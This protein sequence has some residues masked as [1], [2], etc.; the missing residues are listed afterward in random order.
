MIVGVG[1]WRGTGATT[2]AMLLAGALGERAGSAWLVEADAAGGVLASRLGLAHDD[3]DGPGGV[4]IERLASARGDRS[5]EI[6]L[7]EDVG[8]DLGT[9]TLVPAPADPFRAAPCLMSRVGW[10]R[11]L[12]ELSAPVVVDL[13]RLRP[14]AV[15]WPVVGVVDLLLVVT[16]PD[17]AA[18]VAT[19]DWIAASGQVT[20]GDTGFG[21]TPARIAVVDVPG[22]EQ[23]FSRR[24]AEAELGERLAGWL[25]W[26]PDGVAAALGGA[27]L[28]DRRVR[29]R[30]LAS[31][32]GGLAARVLGDA[33]S[34]REVART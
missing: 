9:F 27:D 34:P 12:P 23:R 11:V 28:A 31:A 32:A 5:G 4:G 8:V 10:T 24:V 6:R 16:T 33:S 2:T 1:C 26:S 18:M 17:A 22:P 3:L 7:L 30:G 25:P 29:R 19:D 20:Q 13:G 21:D 14:G 15:P